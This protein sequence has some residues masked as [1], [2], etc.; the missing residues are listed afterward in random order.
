MADNNT[1]P[2]PLSAEDNNKKVAEDLLKQGLDSVNKPED[3]TAAG[4]ALDSLAKDLVEKKEEAPAPEKK[5]EGKTP[6]VTPEP[7]PEEKSAAEQL[8]AQT[9]AA[10][11]LFKDSPGLPPNASPKSHESF[12]AIKIKAAQEIS[13]REAELEKL[14][15]EIAELQEKTKNPVP[16]DLQKELDDHRN[17]RAKLDVDADPKFKQFDKRIAESHE[18]IYAQLRKSPAVNDDVINAIKKAGGPEKVKFEKLFAAINDPIIQRLVEAKV[19]EIELVHFDK[20]KA[21]DETKE[22]VSKYMEE[23]SKQQQ[24]VASQ[25]QTVTKQR[26]DGLVNQLDWIKTKPVDDKADAATKASVTEHNAFVTEV[27]QQIAAA[28]Q[29]DSAEMRAILLV[30]MAQLFQNQRETAGL[31]KELDAKTKELADVNAKWAKVKES[32]TTRLREGGAP[33]NGIPPKPRPASDQVHDR[34]GDALDAI[35]KQ[36]M[37]AKAAKAN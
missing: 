15:K 37:E 32:S 1:P 29:D 14:K 18:F 30:G 8:K 10:E 12:S 36:V 20:Q 22:N 13:Q 28:L 31:K 21:I 4:D 26:V 25:H 9:E 6:E 2:A 7:T 27:Q 23:R 5:D 16:P 33:P 17:W 3:L 24:A 19:G 35:A 34:A 11:K